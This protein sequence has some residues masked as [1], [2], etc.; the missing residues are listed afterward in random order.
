MRIGILSK[1]AAAGVLCAAIA[2]AS[3]PLEAQAGAKVLRPAD[4][5]TL[6]PSS[7][8]YRGQT[9]TTQVRNSG[10]VKFGD[11]YFVLA[12]LVDTGGYSNQIA[13]RY[14]GYF[15]TEIP[16]RIGGKELHAGAYGIGFV[17]NSRFLVTDVGGHEVLSVD[18][19][20][21]SGLKRP[22]PLQV[23]ANGSGF[24][25]Y[26]GRRYVTFTR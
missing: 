22:M 13:S 23:Q 1:L 17:A 18:S 10:G 15:I 20:T 9:A 2:M 14:Q 6:I 21:D 24:R 8:F 26:A 5:Q 19:A 11:G 12:C 25:L 4:M 16:I 7:V 3:A